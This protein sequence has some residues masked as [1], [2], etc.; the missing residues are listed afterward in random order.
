MPSW[1][2]QVS[3]QAPEALQECSLRD[4]M[5]RNRLGNKMATVPVQ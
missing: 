2:S 4:L 5:L 3:L 1:H